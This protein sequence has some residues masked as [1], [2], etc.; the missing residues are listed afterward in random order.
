[1]PREPRQHICTSRRLQVPK[2]R[3]QPSQSIYVNRLEGPPEA[4]GSMFASQGFPVDNLHQGIDYPSQQQNSTCYNTDRGNLSVA[5]LSTPEV[6]L[7]AEQTNIL[8]IV[9]NGGNVFFTG[10][11]GMS[12]SVHS[13]PAINSIALTGTGKSVLLRAIIRELRHAGK[14][15]AV[16]ATTGIAALGIKGQTLHSFAG[17]NTGEEIAE[18]LY[19]KVNRSESTRRRWQST[20]VWII[21]EGTIPL[22]VA[23]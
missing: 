15:V 14:K 12:E 11:A 8:E 23:E 10:P 21:D 3:S 9:K 6:P 1:M 20:Q 19:L 22:C 18:L 2:F 17:I 4:Q 16:T 13:Y 5:V 7:S